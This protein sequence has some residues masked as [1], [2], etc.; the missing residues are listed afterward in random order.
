MIIIIIIY[1]FNNLTNTK[2][3]NSSQ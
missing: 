1:S 3:P 2:S